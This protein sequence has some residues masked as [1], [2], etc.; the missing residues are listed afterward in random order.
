MKPEDF[1]EIEEEAREILTVI[2]K[3]AENDRVK[4]TEEERDDILRL[5]VGPFKTVNEF[6]FKSSEIILISEIAKFLND[7][8]ENNDYSFIVTTE[9]RTATVQTKIGKLFGFN[10]IVLIHVAF[11]VSLYKICD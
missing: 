11:C 9:K 6:R 5:I 4:L 10:G 8:I 2:N 7:K 3:R 1:P